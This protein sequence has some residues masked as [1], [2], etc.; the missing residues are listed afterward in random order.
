[1]NT[2]DERVEVYNSLHKDLDSLG[3]ETPFITSYEKGLLPTVTSM[4]EAA[5]IA[6]EALLAET[7]DG[8]A[9]RLGKLISGQVPSIRQWCRRY[10][11]TIVKFHTA[12]QRSHGSSDAE[13]KYQLQLAD[14]E[15]RRVHNAL[16]ESLKNFSA[17][18]IQAEDFAIF[19]KPIMWKPGVNL[20]EGITFAEPV[21]FDHVVMTDRD[22]VKNWAIALDCVEEMRK[23]F[24]PDDFPPTT[25]TV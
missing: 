3:E 19:R 11:S 1:M 20:P 17:L 14:E 21:V 13:K 25:G 24:G 9:V 22:L 18:L 5:R 2:H 7:E 10:V 4:T 6:S 15:R 23:L 8:E 16:L 12:K